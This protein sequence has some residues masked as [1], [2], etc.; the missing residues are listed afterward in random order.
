MSRPFGVEKKA[1]FHKILT[2]PCQH[3]DALP[4][5]DDLHGKPMSTLLLAI[6]MLFG[7]AAAS[8]P[9]PI[10]IAYFVPSDR[11]PID[12][13]LER[14]D[15]VMTEVQRFYRDG[16]EAAGYG[17]KTF[18]LDR[19]EH[20]RLCVDLVRGHSPMRDYGR[21]AAHKVREEVKGA[22]ARQG[23]DVDRETL[24][25]FQ[26][27]LDWEGNKATE[28]GP[29][30]GSGSHLAGTAWVYDDQHLDPRL[31]SSKLP[32][33]YYGGPC[34]LG[35]FNSHYIGG[36]AHE[37]GHAFGLPHDCQRESERAKR[38]LSLMGGG[39][40]TYGQQRRGEGPGTFLSAASAM[41]LAC[42]RPFAGEQKDAR[43]RSTCRLTDVDAKFK[44]G[45]LLLTGAVVARPP[46]FGIVALDDWAKIPADYDAVGWTCKIDDS[47]RFRL[48]VGEMRPGLS[49][50]RL[51]VCHANGATSNFAFDYEVD[52]R[53]KPNVDVF[54]CRFALDEAMAAYA[55]G[56]R[57]KVQ[58]LAAELQRRFADLPEV[59]G[60]VSHLLKLIEAGPPLALSDLPAENGWVSITRARFRSAST[61]WGA[62]L[63]DEVPMEVHGQCFL[64]VGGKFFEQGLYAH[65]PSKFEL[66]L[67]GKWARFRSAYGLQDGHPGSVV[68]VVR[69]DG[70][71]LFRSSLV[72]DQA[73]R[74]LDADVQG[75]NLLELSVEDGGDGNNGDWG[76][77]IWPKLQPSAKV[78]R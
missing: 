46:A 5:F 33:G 59:H 40:H 43:T 41:Q 39:N 70:K 1:I 71:E 61:G 60:K 3:S 26:V 30:V 16:M 34:S 27:L 38:G 64:Q 53:G 21:D 20:G 56:D 24:V 57:A 11:Q 18:R 37:L 29:F 17:P 4:K 13:Y 76:V 35:E 58:A 54:R 50:L 48:E 12:G 14:L 52:S 2:G 67:D 9:P 15:R 72:K 73:L 74:K 31:L 7:V 36:L 10:R 22:L 51:K 49:Q 66:E 25:I 47:G 55:A 63:R 45:K 42:S 77:W 19:D 28:I 6:T 78:H 62:P 8:E 23:I 75:V 32:G 68:F 44:D 69:G 65:A